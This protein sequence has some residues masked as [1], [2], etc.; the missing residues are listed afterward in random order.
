MTNRMYR[1]I[2]DRKKKPMKFVKGTKFKYKAILTANGNR[3]VEAK[4]KRGILLS[5]TLFIAA[6]IPVTKVL[7]KKKKKKKKS[8]EWILD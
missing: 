3:S 5:P 7:K 6:M 8:E 4:I 1:N 2:C